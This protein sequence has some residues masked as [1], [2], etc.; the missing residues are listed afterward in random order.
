MLQVQVHDKE[1]DK[2]A[3]T[4]T[5]ENVPFKDGKSMLIISYSTLSQGIIF[6]PSCHIL[7][8]LTFDS[9]FEEITVVSSK[10]F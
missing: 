10:P 5:R 8:T 7:F 4:F 2:G 3:Q 1:S 9:V 6:R